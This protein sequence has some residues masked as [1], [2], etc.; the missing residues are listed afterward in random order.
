MPSAF[1]IQWNDQDSDLSGSFFGRSAPTDSWATLDQFVLEADSY[2]FYLSVSDGVGYVAFVSL[3]IGSQTFGAR[4]PMQIHDEQGS[5]ITLG[6]LPVSGRAIEVQ[7]WRLTSDDPKVH[8][9]WGK[10]GTTNQAIVQ[11]I[12]TGSTWTDATGGPIADPIEIESFDRVM[13]VISDQ[14]SEPGTIG[15]YQ[16]Q[17][18]VGRLLDGGDGAMTITLEQPSGSLETIYTVNVFERLH[19]GGLLAVG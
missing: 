6:P 5:A 7:A 14:S 16:T 19:D 1:R 17:R 8:V 4:V 12:W 11:L 15:V 2:D 10:G 13:L 9:T 18:L 3:V